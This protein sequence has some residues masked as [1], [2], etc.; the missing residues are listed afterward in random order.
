MTAALATSPPAGA[1]DDAPRASTP[2]SGTDHVRLREAFDAHFDFVW[3]S[4]R[5]LGVPELTVDDAAQEVF[6]VLS[7]RLPTVERGAERSFLFATALRVAS[8]SRRADTRRGVRD[9]VG[10]AELVDGAP[11]P[12]QV[13]EQRRRRGILEQVLDTLDV[14]LRTVFVL[15]EL[16]E[17]TMAEIATMLEL[18]PGTVASR[19]RRA[20]EAFQDAATRFRGGR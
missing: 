10:L 2:E 13:I 3:R 4:L 6:L 7:R 19:L 15:Y 17:M 16:E 11:T 1:P 8:T 18:A 12:D 9:D 5:R 14:D 20:R